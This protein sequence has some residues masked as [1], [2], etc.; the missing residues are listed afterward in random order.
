MQS[1]IANEMLGLIRSCTLRALKG[2]SGTLSYGLT[3]RRL[4]TLTSKSL[5]LSPG[6]LPLQ[7]HL[8]MN[9]PGAATSPADANY[10]LKDSPILL[11]SASRPQEEF[12]PNICQMEKYHASS[13]RAELNRPW[14]G[15]IPL[16][17]QESGKNHSNGLQGSQKDNEL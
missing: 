12:D 11:L 13:G 9:T 3:Q 8:S 4:K 15:V 1:C 5:C 10:N 2:K 14:Q 6:S 7:E 16:C 17:W